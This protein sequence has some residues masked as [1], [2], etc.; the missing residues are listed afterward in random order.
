MEKVIT[1]TEFVKSLTGLTPE[2]LIFL[3]AIS[4]FALVGFTLYFSLIVINKNQ[5]KG[6]S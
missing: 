5:K 2:V 4:A 3:T 6:D 1:I